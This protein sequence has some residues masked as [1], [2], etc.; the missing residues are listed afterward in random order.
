MTDPF[1]SAAGQTRLDSFVGQLALITPSRVKSGIKTKFGEIDGVV[2][3]VVILTGEQGEQELDHLT[4]LNAPVVAELKAVLLGDK[5]MH[6][7]RIISVP[8][9]KGDKP[10][11]CLDPPSDEDKDL[12]RAYLARPKAV[13]ADPF[14]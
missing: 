1:S 2:A 7:A 9:S 10:V 8:N 3:K 11:I 6:L 12:A 13:P 14:A 5:P 4:I